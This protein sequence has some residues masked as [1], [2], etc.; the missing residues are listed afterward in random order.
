MTKNNRIWPAILLILAVFILSGGIVRLL[1]PILLQELDTGLV[2]MIAYVMMFVITIFFAYAIKKPARL[3]IPSL[4]PEPGRINPRLVVGGVILTVAASI[5]M[6]PLIDT[7]PKENLESLTDYMQG[8]LWP[9]LTS[10]IAAPILEEFLFRGIIQQ[11]MIKV[12]GQLGGILTGALIFGLIHL[13][14]QQIVYATVVGIIIGTIYYMT[15]S[16]YTVIAIHFMNNGLAYLLFMVSGTTS[17]LESGI[18]SDNTAFT[19]VYCIS[20]FILLLAAWYA[21]LQLTNR[22]KETPKTEEN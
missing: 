9:M 10:I 2:Q 17:Y 8:G 4:R 15:G 11:N 20:L 21:A 5:V 14:P 18:F 3:D 1:G 12:L 6:T 16:L 7:M 19:I 22:K 13:I